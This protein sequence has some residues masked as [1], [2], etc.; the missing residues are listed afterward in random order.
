[1]YLFI[2]FISSR[3]FSKLDDVMLKDLL[4]IYGADFELFGY[5]S[6]KY[7]DIVKKSSKPPTTTPNVTTVATAIKI[8]TV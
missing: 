4:K 6:T 8:T 3:Y 7:F 1:M 5:N 2:S